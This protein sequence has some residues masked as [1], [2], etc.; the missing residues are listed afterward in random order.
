MAENAPFV[1]RSVVR[2]THT[3]PAGYVFFPR[4]FE[5]LQATVEE[6]F[7]HALGVKYSS[8]ILDQKLGLPTAKMECEF[9]RPS[10]LGEE[11][12]LALTLEKIGR[13]SMTVRFDGYMEGEHR[14]RARSVLVVIEMVNGR[15][16]PIADDLRRRLVAYQV[17]C[18]TE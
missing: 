11:L 1:H 16:V 15:P 13:T 14:L 6:W 18:G 17:A 2:F 5:M 10:V 12:G 9:L 8:F 3:D 7:T 4:Y